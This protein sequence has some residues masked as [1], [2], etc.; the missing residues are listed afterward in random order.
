MKQSYDLRPWVKPVL[1]CVLG[2]ILIVE[3]GSLT[4]SIAWAVGIV[5]ALVGAGKLVG[6]F[7]NARKDLLK[8]C[9]AVILLLVGFSIMGDPVRLERQVGRVI[10]IVLLLSGIRGYVDPFA[11]HEKATSILS[12]I[13]GVLLLVLPLTFSRLAVV[14]CG[15]VVLLIGGGMVLDLLFGSRGGD[16][17]SPDIIDER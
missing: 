12:C 8:L 5:L 6:F 3:P 1:T 9:G 14:I 7:R 10:G 13:M 16:S 2:L 17:G 15:I 4:S 11:A